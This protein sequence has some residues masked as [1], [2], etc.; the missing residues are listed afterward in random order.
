MSDYKKYTILLQTLA[1]ASGSV[2]ARNEISKLIDVMKGLEDQSRATATASASVV[3]G[4]SGLS[5]A[6][7]MSQFTEKNWSETQAQAR[8]LEQQAAATHDV[9]VATV[10]QAQAAGAGAGAFVE[11]DESARQL[12]KSLEGIGMVSRGNVAGGLKMLGSSAAPLA[13]SLGPVIAVL[14]ALAGSYKFG[15]TIDGLLGISD[16]VGRIAAGGDDAAGKLRFMDS[17]TMENLKAEL[18]AIQQFDLTA[19][20]NQ[21]DAFAKGTA[22]IAENTRQMAEAQR[23]YE[24]SVVRGRVARGPGTPGGLTPEEG[25]VLEADINAKT[26]S[27][28]LKNEASR[29]R[30]QRELEIGAMG[31]AKASVTEKQNQMRAA[32]ATAESNAAALGISPDRESVAAAREKN[33]ADLSKKKEQIEF[34]AKTVAEKKV[35]TAEAEKAAQARDA[36][37]STVDVALTT[38]ERLKTEIE[39]AQRLSEAAQDAIRA[40]IRA[41]NQQLEQNTLRQ[42][43]VKN[44]RDTVVDDVARQ[45]RE[46]ATKAAKDAADKQAED[47]RKA[48]EQQAAFDLQKRAR[49]SVRYQRRDNTGALE[50]GADGQPI[51]DTRI[52]EGSSSQYDNGA[53]TPDG[54]EV[55]GK[56]LEPDDV[57]VKRRARELSRQQQAEA[58]DA[59]AGGADPK[60]LAEEQHQARVAQGMARE[61]DRASPQLLKEITSYLKGS[62]ESIDDLLS[63]FE[64]FSGNMGAVRRRLA[65]IESRERSNRS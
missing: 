51:Y 57:F 29:L 28:R 35:M 30:E 36:E 20:L 27:E 48:A 25:R 37:I 43:T 50:V 39:E 17:V 65:D 2:Q 58:A 3:S 31:Q 38:V 8:A 16:A 15:Q 42:T 64:Q 22:E 61:L 41:I 21:I 56:T 55:I 6:L 44:N 11:M 33:D 63:M 1:D 32:Q 53:R 59:A 7:G 4:S 45:E 40:R 10:E 60:T 12:L 54:G 47:D 13:A 62:Q 18:D 19:T 26:E 23:D 49:Y 5:S 46:K 34:H 9:A 24:I 14:A 52:V